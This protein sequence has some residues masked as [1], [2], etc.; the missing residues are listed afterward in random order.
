MHIDHHERLDCIIGTRWGGVPMLKWEETSTSQPVNHFI[1]SVTYIRN[2]HTYS[3][4]YYYCVPRPASPPYLRPSHSK[5]SRLYRTSQLGRGGQMSSTDQWIS[6]PFPSHCFINTFTTLLLLFSTLDPYRLYLLQLQPRLPGASQGHGLDQPTFPSI[7]HQ[8]LRQIHIT[9][10]DHRR[11]GRP[12]TVNIPRQRRDTRV[13]LYIDVTLAQSS[14]SVTN[15]RHLVRLPG[16]S[17]DA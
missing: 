7:I 17:M 8:S 11:H 12:D 16:T 5:A 6:R 10:Y 4:Y 9:H 1:V 15:T 3:N 14:A 2:L 13:G